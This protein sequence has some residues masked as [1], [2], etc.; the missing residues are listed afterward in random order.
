LNTRDT[1]FMETPAVAATSS[2]LA[3]MHARFVSHAHRTGPMPHGGLI[4]RNP[5]AS[6]GQIDKAVIEV[7]VGVERSHEN[8]ISAGV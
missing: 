2:I 4:S 1:V 3:G 6:F 5:T 8:R 7:G